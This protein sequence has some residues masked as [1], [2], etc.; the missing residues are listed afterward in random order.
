MCHMTNFNWEKNREH[1][2]EWN[3]LFST[4]FNALTKHT[5]YK[6]EAPLYTYVMVE[7]HTFKKSKLLSLKAVESPSVGK[8]ISVQIENE[9]GKSCVNVYP[10]FELKTEGKIRDI[11]MIMI[12]IRNNVITKVTKPTIV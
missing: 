11:V 4:V 10:Q 12:F 1:I 6:I 8:Y 3:E 7:K 9:D 2:Q 5:E